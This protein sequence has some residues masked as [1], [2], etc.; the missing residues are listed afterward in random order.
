VQAPDA[1]VLTGVWSCVSFIPGSSSLLLFTSA[2]LGRTALL[3]DYIR[4]QPL[5]H[6]TL[7]AQPASLAVAPAGQLFA[8]GLTDGCVVLT[9]ATSESSLALRA[10]GGSAADKA[11]AVVQA[12]GFAAGGSKLVAAVGGVITVWDA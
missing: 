7:T 12:V 1:D 5:R 11:Q 8:F 2:C 6:L 10:C 9:S 3:F 4:G